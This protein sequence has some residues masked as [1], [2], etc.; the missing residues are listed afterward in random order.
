MT[1]TQKPETRR[2]SLY[3]SDATKPKARKPRVVVSASPYGVRIFNLDYASYTPTR[4]GL[5]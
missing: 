5:L 4:K 1:T 3:G 2:P